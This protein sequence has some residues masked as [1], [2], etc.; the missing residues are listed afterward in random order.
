[1]GSGGAATVYRGFDNQLKEWRAIK[2]LS[3]RLTANTG[4]RERFLG[5]ARAMAK[6]Q[7]RNIVGLH[8]VGLRG[9]TLYLVM[10]LVEGG[11]VAD[12]V[13]RSGPLPPRMCVAVT[14]A[15][16][17]GLHEAHLREVVHRDI[18]PHNVLISLHGTAKITDF[19]I[20]RLADDNRDL[21]RTGAVLG[22]MAYM[23][24]EQRIDTKRA[25][26]ATDIY[27]TG[28]T[29]YAMLS[30][31]SP[32]NLEA[33]QS[34]EKAFVGL[35]VPLC[36]VIAKACA[37]NASERYRDA[38]AMLEALLDTFKA[39]PPDP[40]DTPPLAMAGAHAAAQT[41]PHP[42]WLLQDANS[43]DVSQ[44]GT[45]VRESGALDRAKPPDPRPP[46]QKANPLINTMAIGLIGATVLL[47][48]WFANAVVAPRLAPAPADFDDTIPERFTP[49]AAPP[50]LDDA[51]STDSVGASAQPPK[52]PTWKKPKA[53][54]PTPS[55]EQPAIDP[56]SDVNPWE[57]ASAPVH[58][59]RAGDAVAGKVEATLDHSGPGWTAEERAVEAEAEPEPEEEFSGTGQVCVWRQAQRMAANVPT[60]VYMDNVQLG[61]LRSGR[62][63][64]KKIPAGHHLLYVAVPGVREDYP[65]VGAGARLRFTVMAGTTAARPSTSKAPAERPCSSPRIGPTC[66]KHPHVKRAPDAEAS[67][68]RRPSPMLGK[69]LEAAALV[70]RR[71]DSSADVVWRARTVHGA[72]HATPGIERDDWS[73]LAVVRAQTGAAC[74]F[75]VVFAVHQ[76]SLDVVWRR[77]ELEVVDG[78]SLGIAAAAHDAVD[79][80]VVWDLEQQHVVEL[81]AVLVQRV[82]EG[83]G[84]GN[85]P[86]EAVQH[87]T[88][89]CVFHRQALAHHANDDLV[90]HQ[91]AIV[92]VLLGFDAHRCAG[93]D[94]GPE[95]VPGRDV[96]NVV[97][98]DEACGLGAFSGPGGSDEDHAHG[99]APEVRGPA[100]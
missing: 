5:E 93:L 71:E 76:A 1:V 40:P 15:I 85:R 10:E 94:R 25:T 36:N 3:P 13:G 33:H 12:R 82:F 73:R 90:G 42:E 2:V 100:S 58:A 64:C 88:I 68:F 46:E 59:P 53:P 9:E 69:G 60:W 66:T 41:G 61:S 54:A 45:P 91:V 98:F 51:A 81:D 49:P 43:N 75:G 95:H 20:A 44:L 21:T 17:A 19:G 62:Y 11:S 35:P 87:P 8:D 97:A 38:E 16:L 79:D 74:V 65:D 31:K 18:K 63:L 23:S 52:P 70:Q 57:A 6:F 56:A 80:E 22:T 14:E 37:Y 27:A 55:P 30:G 84:L 26:A 28:A 67:G 4:A 48:I 83:F 50:R 7:H 32:M 39:L 86:R 92:H 29:L 24:P 78:S 99:C 47:A 72:Q 77:I 96:G 34:H 89:E